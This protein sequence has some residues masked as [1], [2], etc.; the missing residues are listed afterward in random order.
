MGITSLFFGH[1]WIPHGTN[2]YILHGQPSGICNFKVRDLI[3]WTNRSWRQPL[4][5]QLFPTDVVR[6][7]SL[8]IFLGSK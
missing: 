1:Q 8:S 4:L 5:N 3:D 2:P 7:L 6:K